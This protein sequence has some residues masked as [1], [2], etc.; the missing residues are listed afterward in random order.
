MSQ[1]IGVHGI[2]NQYRGRAQILNK[3]VPALTD[4]LHWA[5][6]HPPTNPPDLDLAFYGHL[7]RSAADPSSKGPTDKQDAAERNK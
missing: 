4:G 6:G 5:I 3:W 2:G 1:L 7:F